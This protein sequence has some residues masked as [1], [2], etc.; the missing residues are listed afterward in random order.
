MRTLITTKGAAL[1]D[2]GE[3][4][5]AARLKVCHEDGFWLDIQAPGEEDLKILEKVFGFHHLTIEDIQ[6][7]DQR[8]KLE[9]YAGYT[10]IVIFTAKLA[11]D[12][13]IQFQ[14]HHM[15][16][17]KDYLVTV[18]DDP[19][20]IL[21]TLA[22]RVKRSPEL[23]KGNPGFL[24]YLVIDD[25]VDSLFPLLESLDDRIDTLEDRILADA[26]PELLGQINQYKRQVI[27]LR[28]F[29]G[30]QRDLFQ[31]LITHSIDVRGEELTLYWRDVHDHL[32]RQ[33]ETVDSLRDLLTGAMDIYLSTVSNRL[34]NTM[35]A[36]T[37]I[38]S[39]FLPLTF[40]TG[41]FGMNFL[42]LTANLE[43][44]TASFWIGVGIMVFS[45][46]IQFY[47]FKRRGWL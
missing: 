33:Y 24:T 43:P 47:F 26:T 3:K 42:Y 29:I 6:H 46:V 37:V 7:Q 23:T 44:S 18:H 22:D 25:L 39:L 13:E 27:E 35:K 17:S 10:F 16:V 21:V 5:I 4:A 2:P 38:A 31:R 34:N 9:E 19:A 32:I 40:L 36:L 14:E 12:G 8:P 1:D 45:V 20:E 41:F 11:A 30:A 15:F 28:K